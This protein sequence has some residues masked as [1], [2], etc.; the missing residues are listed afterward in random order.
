MSWVQIDDN[1]PNHPKVIQAGPVAAWLYVCGLAYCRRYNT[2]GFIPAKAVKTLGVTTNPRRL[3]DALIAA[4]LWERADKGF[5]V[6]DYAVHYPDDSA[7]KD[8]KDAKLQQ[9]REAGRRGGLASAAKRKQ[10][11]GQANASAE[12]ERPATTVAQ[13]LIGEGDGKGPVLVL[14]KEERKVERRELPPLDVWLGE[15]QRAYPQNRAT[16]GHLT[17]TAFVD[18]FEQDP[19]DPLE[20]WAEMRANLAINVRSHE[21]RVKGMAPKLEKYLREGLWRQ[22]HADDAP[23]AERLTTKTNRTLAAAAAIM[24]EP[25]Q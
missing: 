9:T 15:L 25:K 3:I 24:Q 12:T 17:V 11:N 18:Q 13:P 8:K 21:W 5:A 20:V 1:F 23:V 14:V 6:H 22:Q 4:N 2:G 16:Y 7:V 10:A 19:R